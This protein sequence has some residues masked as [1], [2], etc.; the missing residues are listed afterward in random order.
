M[1]TTVVITIGHGN[2]PDPATCASECEA[3][4]NYWEGTVLTLAEGHGYWQGET[5]ATTVIIGTIPTSAGVH[6]L[7][8]DLSALAI[9]YKQE[10]IGF[11]IHDHKNH[12]NSYV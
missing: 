8:V 12:P 11:I 9:Q 7:G 5:E 2:N 6:A 4:L 3:A 10:A 1:D